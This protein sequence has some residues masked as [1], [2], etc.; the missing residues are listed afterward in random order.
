MWFDSHCHLYEIED[1]AA[2]VARAGGAGVT[3]MVVLGTDRDSS[4][5]ALELARYEGVWAGCG[6]HPTSS[7]GWHG[8]W[9]DAV[10]E[11][12]ADERVVAV[13]ESGLDL[14]RD[15][16]YLDDQLAAFRA[17]IGMARRN[18]KALV[19]HTRASVDEA[20]DVLEEV[21]PPERFVFHCWSGDP[22]Q[23]KR[24]LGLGA[25]IS[26]AGNVS[27]KKSLA[28]RDAASSVPDDRLLIETDSPYL[29][30][31]PRRGRSNEPA[32]VVHVGEAVAGARGVPAGDLALLTTG[33]ARRFFGLE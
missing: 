4:V 23:L 10:E 29:A 14:H 30:P 15:D 2:A 5:R 18:E 24:A 7:R 17:H 20:L 6:V 16:T 27:F 11:L 21:G 19:I 22:G 1:P 12:L 25:M 28:L 9:A 3:G 8:S 26:F 13:G 31:E 33:N 32:F